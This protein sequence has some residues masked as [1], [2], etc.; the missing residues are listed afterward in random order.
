VFERFYR[1]DPSRMRGKG[2]GS[3]LGLAIVAAVVGAHG[4][5]VGVAP[6]PGGGATFVVDLPTAHSQQPPSVV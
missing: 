5:K 4:G 6:T 1:A 3:G 2:G